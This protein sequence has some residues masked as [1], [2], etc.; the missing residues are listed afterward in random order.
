M[1][2]LIRFA[3]NPIFKVGKNS[4]LE[5]KMPA[6]IVKIGRENL[7]K[8]IS[9]VLRQWP[10]LERKIFSQAHYRGQSLET[11][12]HSLQLDVEEVGAILKQCN[13]RLHASLRN[14]RKSSCEKPSRI[15]AETACPAACEQDLKVAHALGSKVNHILDI[16]QISA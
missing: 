7:F 16:S 10:E 11:I 2:Y 14:F 6:G 12:S 4:D 3:L 1:R 15:P 13:R 5:I 9:S 8:E